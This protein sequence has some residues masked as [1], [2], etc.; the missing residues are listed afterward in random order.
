MSSHAKINNNNKTKT[1]KKKLTM[2][3]KYETKQH[4]AAGFQRLSF[5]IYIITEQSCINCRPFC[6]HY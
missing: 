1:I 3:V 5:L 2:Y 6:T 4:K